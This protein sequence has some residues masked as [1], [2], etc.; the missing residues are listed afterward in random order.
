MIRKDVRALIEMIEVESKIAGLGDTIDLLDFAYDPQMVSAKLAEI[1]LQ[2]H[3][4]IG[5]FIDS[6]RI[7]QRKLTN[8]NT[9]D[10]TP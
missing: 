1:S 3:V 8:K 7:M 2:L 9:D 5:T 10:T 4:A 6:S